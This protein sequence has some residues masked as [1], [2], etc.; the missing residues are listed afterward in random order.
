MAAVKAVTHPIFAFHIFPSGQ[1]L[2]RKVEI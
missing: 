1:E 2:E